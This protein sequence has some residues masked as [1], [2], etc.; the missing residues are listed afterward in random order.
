M[1]KDRVL[2]M[3]EANPGGITAAQLR[4]QL[5]VKGRPL[6]RAIQSLLRVRA[7]HRLGYGTY[8]VKARPPTV[9]GDRVERG[10]RLARLM[11]GR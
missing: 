7:I 9:D 3:I 10:Q 11:S 1:L 2:F 6:S 8:A 5:G 4:Q